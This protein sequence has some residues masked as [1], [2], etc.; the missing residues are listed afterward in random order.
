MDTQTVGYQ[1][2]R[3]PNPDKGNMDLLDGVD[4]FLVVLLKTSMIVAA[5]ALLF[6]LQAASDQKGFCSISYSGE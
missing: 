3:W 4:V 2:T 6:N 5:I 1:R